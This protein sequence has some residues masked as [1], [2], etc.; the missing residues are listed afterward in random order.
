MEGFYIEVSDTGT[1]I[2]PEISDR[3]FQAFV[4]T[5]GSRGTGL[6]LACCERLIRAH[7][8]EIW[9]ESEAGKGT[10]FTVFLPFDPHSVVHPNAHRPTLLMG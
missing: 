1:G 9:V 4:S 3:L 5:K 6:G 10:T 8:G 7:H 2:P